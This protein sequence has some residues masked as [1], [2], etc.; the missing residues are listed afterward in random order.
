LRIASVEE[1]LASLSLLAEVLITAAYWISAR[2]LREEYGIPHSSFSQFTILAMGKLGGGELNFSSDVDLMYVYASGQK[3]SGGLTAAEYF[4]RLGQRITRGLSEFTGEGYVY[5]VD[6]RLRPEGVAGNIADPV[7]GYERYYQ[8]RMS[9]W[10]RL[11]LLKAWPVAGNRQLAKSFLEMAWK[12]IHA[13]PFDVQTFEEVRTM[14]RQT[15]QQAA[16]RRTQG[17]NV[18]LGAGGIREIELVTQALQARHGLLGRNTL[19]AL[20]A[21]YDQNI[22]SGDDRARL[23]GAYV[24]LRDVENKLQMVNDAQTHTLPLGQTELI[25]IARLLG[26]ADADAFAREYQRHT[27]EVNTI[28]E[29]VANRLF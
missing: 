23:A 16:A 28:F 6:L 12:F 7:D 19:Q 9:A 5:R 14:K 1:T 8:S 26:Y 20:N 11:A 15:D 3:E 22:L 21:L 25:V 18:K 17:H 27:G 2:A 4:H 13:T 24:F 10:E 29:D